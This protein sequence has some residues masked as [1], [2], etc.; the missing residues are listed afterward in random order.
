MWFGDFFFVCSYK[1]FKMKV[2]LRWNALCTERTSIW[3]SYRKPYLA[4]TA[5]SNVTSGQAHRWKRLAI[6]VLKR[7]MMNQQAEP[8]EALYRR[9]FSLEDIGQSSRM[10]PCVLLSS[11]VQ[12]EPYDVQQRGTP[13][14]PAKWT[15][16]D[17]SPTYL[18]VHT[19]NPTVQAFR[20]SCKSR[21][22]PT[23]L[24]LSCRR[25]LWWHKLK[26]TVE[27]YRHDLSLHLKSEPKKYSY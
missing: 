2:F 6:L 23:T 9:V 19:H 7:V 16:A 27:Q 5:Q 12:A 18:R 14:A 26:D 13:G 25:K 20:P 15:R 8:V 3:N 21:N 24:A 22:I 11:L 4:L 10:A 17:G 1:K